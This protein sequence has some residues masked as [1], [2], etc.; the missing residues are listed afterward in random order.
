MVN[1]NSASIYN[2]AIIDKSTWTQLAQLKTQLIAVKSKN[3]KESKDLP[4]W[5]MT[6][7]LLQTDFKSYGLI[8]MHVVN[9]VSGSFSNK[10]LMAEVGVP[11]M[12][13]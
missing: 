1:K 11:S 3:F 4:K 10:I 9:R 2:T 5:L 13:L 8:W 7:I 12:S 6:G